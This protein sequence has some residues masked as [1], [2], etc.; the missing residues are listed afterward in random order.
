SA[1]YTNAITVDSAGVQHG[2]FNDVRDERIDLPNLLRTGNVLNNS[3][4]L[5]RAE[6][7]HG[8]VARVD[9]I[10]FQVH[11]WLAQRG[12]L[13]HLGAPLSAYRVGS[14]ASLVT[15]SN[16]RVRELY[17]QAIQSVPR[18]LVSED[19]FAHA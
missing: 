15:A 8:W 6:H 13:Y 19:D 2:R 17:W 18:H 14:A 9:Q 4:V 7:V 16:E 5:F 11:L 3:S 10:D 12:W 1:V